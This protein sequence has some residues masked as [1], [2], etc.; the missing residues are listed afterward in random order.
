M[1]FLPLNADAS[2]ESRQQVAELEKTLNEYRG[3][4]N[5]AWQDAATHQEGLKVAE[6]QVSVEGVAGES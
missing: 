6:A 5:Q 1:W 4:L 3:M 2:K